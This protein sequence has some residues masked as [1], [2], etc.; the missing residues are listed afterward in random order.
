MIC[1]RSY[2]RRGMG[3]GTGSWRVEH[4]HLGR[5]E[6]FGMDVEKMRPGARIAAALAVLVP[7]VLSGLFLVAFVPGMWWIFTIYGWVVFPAFGLLARG[8]A[9]VGEG[10]PERATPETRERELLRVLGERGEVTP[11]GVAAETSLTVE[12]ADRTLRELAEGGH[13]EVRVRGGGIFYS[14]WG[15][16]PIE[17]PR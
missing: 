12:E 2:A 1:G 5:D 15:G 8:L 10:R 4:R 3:F 6:F 17:G 7:V 14:L 11:A 9:G 13:L 16:D